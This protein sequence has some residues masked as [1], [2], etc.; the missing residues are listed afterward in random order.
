M[1]LVRKNRALLRNTRLSLR[2]HIYVVDWPVDCTLRYRQ[3]SFFIRTIR[4]WDS[5]RAE[6]V[7]FWHLRDVK[8]IRYRKI[9]NF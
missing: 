7:I 1:G 5:L 2:P 6:V 3:N 8:D 4:M 9:L